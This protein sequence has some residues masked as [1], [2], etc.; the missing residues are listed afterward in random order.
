MGSKPNLQRG[1]QP[2]D[3]PYSFS[4]ELKKK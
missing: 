4:N 1:T 2:E 3:Y